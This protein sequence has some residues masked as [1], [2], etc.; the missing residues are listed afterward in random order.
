MSRQ[1]GAGAVEMRN[2]TK[3]LLPGRRSF[4][5][6][7]WEIMESFALQK[8]PYTAQYYCCWE[9]MDKIK[10]EFHPRDESHFIFLSKTF[11]LFSSLLYC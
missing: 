10:I 2:L 9:R 1:R 3:T 6:K 5:C 11:S 4:C 7:K 8:H